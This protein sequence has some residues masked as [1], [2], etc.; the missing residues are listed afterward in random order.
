MRALF[1]ILVLLST[2]CKP[3]PPHTEELPQ[4]IT[5]ACY[6]SFYPTLRAWE[7]KFGRAPAE[8]QLL[9]KVYTV[10]LTETSSM[11]SCQRTAIGSNQQVTGCTETDTKSILILKGRSDI[12]LTDSSI[13]EWIHTLAHC[14]F[15]DADKE[16]ARAQLWEGYGADTVEVRTHFEGVEIGSCL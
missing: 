16:H 2:S 11:A 3:K 12:Q 9:D 1:L 4:Q 15:K 10:Y 7:T 14:V 8:C 6:R 13:H 5:H